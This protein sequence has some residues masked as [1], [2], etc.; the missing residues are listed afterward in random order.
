LT[1]HEREDRIH[2][3]CRI[4]EFAYPFIFQLAIFFKDNKIQPALFI[5]ICFRSV[6]KMDNGTQEDKADRENDGFGKPKQEI[7]ASQKAQQDKNLQDF[8][9]LGLQCMRLDKT[10]IVFNL[11]DQFVHLSTPIVHPPATRM[12]VT[13]AWISS[14]A[15]C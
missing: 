7:I 15:D 11:V 4:I 14:Y 3:N 9:P 10:E 13:I 12:R 2:D 5:L 1:D 6:H 8:E